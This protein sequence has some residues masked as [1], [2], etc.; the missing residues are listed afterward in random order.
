MADETIV[1]PKMQALLLFGA[2]G[3]IVGVLSAFNTKLAMIALAGIF[4]LTCLLLLYH[5]VIRVM[6]ARKAK[7]MSG[8]MQEHS[9][10]APNGINDPAKRARLD[11]LKRNF[12]TGM[13]KFRTAGKDVYKLPW[14]LFVGEPGSG[15]TE[16]VRHCNVGFPP[17]LQDELQGVGGTINMNWWFTN[18]AVL[19]DTAGRLMFEEVKPG[20]TS[21]WREFLQLLRRNRP[22]CPIN[23]LFL[24]IPAESLIR[25][26]AD[27]IGKKAGK[28]AQQLDVIQ[29]TLDVRF[30]VFVLITKCDLLSGFREFF[31][32]LSDPQMQHQMIGWSNPD[33]R[34][35]AFRP[36]LVVDH[37]KTVV[38]R[39]SKRRLGLLRDPVS[40][41]E[42]GKRADEVD[43]LFG[44][45]QSLELIGPRLRSYL[46]TVFVAG[47]WS[48][49]PLFLRGIY[50]TSAM[51]EGA[52]LDQELAQTLGMSLDDLPEG[53]AWE[54]ER[55]YFLRD[56]FI[57]KAFRERGLV[58]RATN[59]TALLRTRALLLYGLGALALLA[60][61]TFTFLGYQALKTS[62][63]NQSRAWYE[64]SQHWSNGVWR[65]IVERDEQGRV[66]Y[67]GDQ[68]AYAGAS[69]PL[70]Q[71]HQYVEELATSNIDIPWVFKPLA[72]LARLTG[73]RKKGQRVLFEGGVVSPLVKEARRRMVD[74]TRKPEANVSQTAFA[75]QE[76]EGLAALIR[77]EADLASHSTDATL[78]P[79]RFLTPL[80]RYSTGLRQPGDAARLK[81]LSE[82]LAWTYSKNPHG[83]W[84]PPWLSAGTSLPTNRPI[85]AGLDRVIKHATA[86]VSNQES[87]LQ[88][89]RQVMEIFRAF[90][91]KEAELNST[92]VSPEAKDLVQQKMD[93]LFTELKTIKENADKAVKEAEA[94]GMV[95]GERFTAGKAYHSLI[96]SSQGEVKDAFGVIEKAIASYTAKTDDPINTAY[97]IFL[98]IDKK[99]K[100]ANASVNARIA[101]GFTATEVEE[102]NKVDQ[103]YLAD[104]GNGQRNYEVRWTAYDGAHAQLSKTPD[105][106]NLIGQ[107]WTPLA[108][109]AAE[110]G[111][112]RQTITT[113]TGQLPEPWSASCKY[114]VNLAEQVRVDAI[115]K[116]YVDQSRA[117]FDANF[118]PPIVREPRGAMMKRS[119]YPEAER[120]IA[121]WKA[122]MM[123]EPIK[124]VQSPRKL[125]LD[126]FVKSLN[127]ISPAIGAFGG[128]ATVSL[129]SYAQ[130]PERAGLNHFRKVVVQGREF[131]TSTDRVEGTYSF[132]DSFVAEF[133]DYSVVPQKSYQY[134]IS[135][136]DLIN[137][138]RHGGGRTSIVVQG[139]AIWLQVA[140]DR[141][142]PE[143]TTVPEKQ[144]ILSSLK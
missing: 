13:E 130:T 117:V 75:L 83:S 115:L 121:S 123:A 84:P 100:E 131:D 51:R 11:D 78:L 65:P 135:I 85:L 81:T 55:A 71:Y 118:H 34:D 143:P 137:K 132:F 127:L 111:T 125:A 112:Q 101:G 108:T 68:P 49:K 133:R 4:V 44:F 19:L 64:A 93:K 97:P 52:A 20:E 91:A 9:A 80:L 12:D 18:H 138:S 61:G 57:E 98:Q 69:M 3:S 89:V 6:Q 94:K 31:E 42:G 26:S 109:T 62:V 28:I 124:T 23:G 87:N 104:F 96:V 73:D 113:L 103:L 120:L 142:M 54:R 66:H 30:P 134:N 95:S 126:N 110:I 119:D 82:V 136:V 141:Q 38:E 25:D 21:E 27:A 16:A 17:G 139:Y 70:A 53:R 60:V 114:Y 63:G 58:T 56:L 47:E 15:K 99:L 29:R 92:A 48:A 129:L 116:A 106:A 35:V 46:E 37:L 1:S 2:G 79:D 40:Q 122:D 77:I 144:P 67:A 39:V 32:E 72:S 59:T 43:A 8:Q 86:G 105:T 140:A 41:K 102:L 128:S 36:E 7:S 14:Y 88:C 90:R 24:V 22:N 33:P 107:N 10:A 50:F 5:R 76:A 45:P 74:T